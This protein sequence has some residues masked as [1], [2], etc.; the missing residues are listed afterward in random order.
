MN[1]LRLQIGLLAAE[2]VL[3]IEREQ[4]EV[5]ADFQPAPVK[6]HRFKQNESDQDQR[7]HRTFQP[8]DV[9]VDVEGALNIKKYYGDKALTVFVEPPNVATL[10]NR[11]RRRES[12]TEETLQKR[13]AKAVFELTYKDK[14]DTFVLN[15]DLTKA[16][17]DAIKTVTTFLKYGDLLSLK[18]DKVTLNCS[19]CK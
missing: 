18:I 7:K 6:P 11:L 15:D 12:E 9:D 16:K 3:A 13:I 2:H 10:E 17:E 4:L 8:G 1:A 5:S 19:V 14:F